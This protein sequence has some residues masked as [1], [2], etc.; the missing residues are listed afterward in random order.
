MANS[1]GRGILAAQ[2]LAGAVLGLGLAG[3]F[4]DK[5]FDSEPT[6]LLI[7]LLLGVV[8]GF[9]ELWKAMFPREDDR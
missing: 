1:H 8:V 7:G 4:L 9:Y 6:L 2:T 3:Y 5:K